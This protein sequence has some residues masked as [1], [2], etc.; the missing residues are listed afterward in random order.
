MCQ[1]WL[2]SRKV[3]ARAALS[4]LDTRARKVAMVEAEVAITNTIKKARMA[5]KRVLASLMN[6]KNVS[7]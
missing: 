7:L 6:T 5:F 4:N 3:S 1:L 2:S